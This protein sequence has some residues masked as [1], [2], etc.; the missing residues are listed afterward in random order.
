MLLYIQHIVTTQA[1]LLSNGK[2]NHQ[3]FSFSNF[4]MQLPLCRYTATTNCSQK[5]TQSSQGLQPRKIKLQQQY[6]KLVAIYCSSATS[7]FIKI[8]TL[9]CRLYKIANI[10]LAANTLITRIVLTI[11][12]Y[13]C[14]LKVLVLQQQHTFCQGCC[15][16]PSGWKELT[17]S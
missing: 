15:Q 7:S 12:Q 13:F 16:I 1:M 2:Q 5:P 10:T 11:H 3:R 4:I 9:Q 8:S 6:N 17:L 14:L